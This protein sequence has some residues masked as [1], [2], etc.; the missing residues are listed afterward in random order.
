MSARTS[1]PSFSVR[2]GQA[3]ICRPLTDKELQ[4]ARY[5]AKFD[6]P[7]AR[8]AKA[9][10]VSAVAPLMLKTENN[11]GGLP[12]AVF[13]GFRTA[14]ADNRA[15]FFLDVP[16]GPKIEQGVIW[17]WRQGGDSAW[18]CGDGFLGSKSRG[19]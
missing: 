4:V 10:L 18:F 5:V 11:A 1:A 19:E 3:D 2:P 15:Q 7:Q 8:V 9:V 12:I 14:L 13:D 17:N 16:S 6:E